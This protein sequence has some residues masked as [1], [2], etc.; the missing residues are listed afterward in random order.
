M[1]KTPECTYFHHN[2]D[3]E[4]D[5]DVDLRV[6]PGCSVTVV[7]KL[8][9]DALLCPRVVVQQRHQRLLLG[10]L[11]TG[12]QDVVRVINSSRLRRK[13]SSIFLPSQLL[14]LYVTA[15]LFFCLCVCV[16]ARF[17]V[18][19]CLTCSH[20]IE[21]FIGTDKRLHLSHSLI[22]ERAHEREMKKREQKERKTM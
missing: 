4:R 18:R 5:E 17:C 14:I 21:Y 3:D 6:L 15:Y 12:K 11:Q 2:E 16:C 8:L 22:K 19:H 20:F 9:S 1:E 13:D 7:L 10:Q